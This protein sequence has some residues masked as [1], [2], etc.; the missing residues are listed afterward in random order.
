M[1][2]GEFKAVF[3]EWLNNFNAGWTFFAETDK[4]IIPIGF[5]M[6]WTRGRIVEIADIVWFPWASKRNVWESALN[7]Y[8]SLRKKE[9]DTEREPTDPARYFVV[10][11][12]ARFRDKRFFERMVD[13]KILRKVGHVNDLYPD[14]VSVLFQTRSPVRSK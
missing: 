13:K 6:A 12:Y 9:A 10:L 11:E 5:C 1:T 4:G 3:L 2:P 14:E 7:F 8:D